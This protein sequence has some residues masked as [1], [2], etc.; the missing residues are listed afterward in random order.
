M[1]RSS[2]AELH[3]LTSIHNLASICEHGVLSHDLAARLSHVDLSNEQIQ[4]ERKNKE[5]AYASQRRR[6]KLHSYANLF[7]HGRNSM[8]KALC[9]T[10][11]HNTIAVVRVGAEVLDLPDVV[12][13]DQN[14][15]SKYV[16]FHASPAG[17]RYLNE[18]YVFAR[19]WG[20][21]TLD[22]IDYWRRK[23]RR[24]AEVLVPDRV[25]P[26]HLR[27]A[28]V[29]CEISCGRCEA[30]ALPITVT[31]DGDLFFRS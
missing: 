11:G 27:G 14:A 12:I 18:D 24:S 3:Y 20:D 26:L 31:I 5:V 29:S 13:A 25:S 1:D 9:H 22:Q 8:L 28:Y 21:P 7:L 10:H 23:S 16:H 30:M 6:R 15:A 4:D 2:L 17:L 19:E